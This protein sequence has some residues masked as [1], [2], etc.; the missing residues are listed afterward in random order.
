MNNFNTPIVE[1]VNINKRLN[2]N[3]IYLK[4]ESTNPISH[5]FKDRGALGVIK[6]MKKENKS[7][8]LAGTCSNMGVAISGMASKYAMNSIVVISNSAPIGMI[9]MIR[10]FSTKSIVIDGGFDEVDKFIGE[11]SEEF[12]D[13]ACVNTNFN[14]YFF[15][16]YYS[17]IDELNL[18]LDK[19]KT[20]HVIVPTADGTLISSLYKRYKEISQNITMA[21]LIFHIA[22]PSGCSPIVDAI[23]KNCK[24]EPLENSLTRVIPLSVKR[25][26]IYGQSAIKA[27][28]ETGGSGIKINESDINDFMDTLTKQ[29]GIYSDNVGGVLFGAIYQLSKKI[30]KDEN[31]LGIYTGNGLVYACENNEKIILSQ[32]IAK[33]QIYKILKEK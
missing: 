2:I 18:Q 17:I 13:I 12:P 16:G 6:Q 5:T 30:K 22:Q 8:V 23:N 4:L 15:K 10:K 33:E 31:I 27:V 7:L 14:K 21:R 28:L 29:E 24:I 3:N 20:Y 32:Q 1:L 9:N 26:L 19:G 25:P 11:L